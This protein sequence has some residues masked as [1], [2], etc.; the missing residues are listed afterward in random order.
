MCAN[1]NRTHAVAHVWLTY[2][3][4]CCGVADEW[5]VC[6]V[7]A[8][9]HFLWGPQH[10]KMKRAHSNRV[11]GLERRIA[12]PTPPTPALRA[13]RYCPTAQYRRRMC[14]LCGGYALC[15]VLGM[16]LCCGVLTGGMLLRGRYAV[17]DT[18][19]GRADTTATTTRRGSEERAPEAADRSL[20]S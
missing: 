7:W 16:L 1:G 15:A 17:S 12:G 2:T 4:F 20:A 5:A 13:P 11:L 6:D 3:T 18:D 19:G 8:R 14:S 9:V 10:M